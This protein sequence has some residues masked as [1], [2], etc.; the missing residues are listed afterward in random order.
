LIVDNKLKK[1]WVE[2]VVG[3]Y[4]VLYRYLPGGTE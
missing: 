4:K 3:L 2:A 1:M